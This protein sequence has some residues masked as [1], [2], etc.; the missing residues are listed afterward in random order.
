MLNR[1]LNSL[2]RAALIPLSL[3]GC[4]AL[5]AGGSLIGPVLSVAMYIVAIAAP[6]VLGY[7]IYRWTR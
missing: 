7:Y 2:L 5:S 4:Q 1:F 6:F 3:G